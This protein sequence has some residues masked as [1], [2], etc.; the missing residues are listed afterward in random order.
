MSK[1]A[2]KKFVREKPELSQLV[3]KGSTTWQKLYETY[4]LYGGT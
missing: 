4:D 3:L 1:E 2:F